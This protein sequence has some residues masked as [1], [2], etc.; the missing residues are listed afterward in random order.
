M[1]AE[2]KSYVQSISSSSEGM[3]AIINDVLDVSALEAGKLNLF[4]Q[5]T[6]V[7]AIVSSVINQTVSRAAA[8]DLTMHLHIDEDVPQH[9]YTDGNRL[10]QI[11]VNLTSNSGR[12]FFIYITYT[13]A[14][15]S[16][17]LMSHADLH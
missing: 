2:C 13:P 11:L 14:V 7:K 16:S 12:C 3:S 8:K 1:T 4:N 10:T 17:L 6:D 15:T 9:V 5:V